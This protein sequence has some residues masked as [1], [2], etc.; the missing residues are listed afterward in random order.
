MPEVQIAGGVMLI[1]KVD[2]PIITGRKVWLYHGYPAIWR[3]G[4]RVYLHRVI[5]E[6]QSGEMIDHINR[7]KLDN[8]RRNL[9]LCTKRE[10]SYNRQGPNS[11]NL[12]GY[13]GVSWNRGWVA[14]IQ[15]DGQHFRLGRFKSKEQAARAYDEAALRYFGPFEGKLNFPQD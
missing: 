14:Q 5:L 8:R 4:N 12:S 1:D 9:R 10:N 2:L 3:K 15:A 7:D 6:A 11:N 13:R